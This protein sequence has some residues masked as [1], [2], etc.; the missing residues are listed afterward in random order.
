MLDKI[1]FVV[2][3]TMH[4]SKPIPVAGGV[5]P[6]TQ[7]NLYDVAIHSLHYATV[8]S[9]PIWIMSGVVIYRHKDNIKRLLASTEPKI[10]QKK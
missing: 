6:A 9:F 8:Y 10:G 1:G 3:L 2:V 4:M 5:I 7:F